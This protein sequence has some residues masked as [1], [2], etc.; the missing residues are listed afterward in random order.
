MMDV[1]LLRKW[2]MS[3]CS[4]KKLIREEIEKKKKKCSVI[5]IGL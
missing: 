5:T 2:V 3:V 1:H 4:K